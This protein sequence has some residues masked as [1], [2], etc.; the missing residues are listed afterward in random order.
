MLGYGI[1]GSACHSNSTHAR[2]SKHAS[3]N[4][5]GLHLGLCSALPFSSTVNILCP[6]VGQFPDGRS[7]IL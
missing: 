2:Y 1:V 4:E 3:A 5:V 6:L 7:S